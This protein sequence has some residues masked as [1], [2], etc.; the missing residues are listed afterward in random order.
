MEILY[1]SHEFVTERRRVSRPRLTP[2]DIL[3]Q[4]II[5]TDLSGLLRPPIY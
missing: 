3:L 2:R 1:N 4:S 5:H